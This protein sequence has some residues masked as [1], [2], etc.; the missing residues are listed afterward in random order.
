MHFSIISAKFVVWPADA[1]GDPAPLEICIVGRDPFSPAIERELRTRKVG[2][3]AVEVTTLKPADNLSA[4]HM[5]FI[6]ATE[7]DQAAKIVSS[8]RDPAR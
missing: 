1:Y 7:K 3:R 4:C 6:P 5:A 8:L 2:G